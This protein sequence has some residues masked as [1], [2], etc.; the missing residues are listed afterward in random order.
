M[1][2]LLKNSTTSSITSGG[3]DAPG[4]KCGGCGAGSGYCGGEAD[5]RRLCEDGEGVERD[6]LARLARE[7]DEPTVADDELGH[8]DFFPAFVRLNIFVERHEVALPEVRADF[9]PELCGRDA[10]ADEAAGLCLDE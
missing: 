3:V 4:G 9:K 2:I 8:L 5:R 7:R 1:L 6:H 10:R